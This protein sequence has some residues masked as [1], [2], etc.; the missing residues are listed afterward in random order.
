LFPD[1]D[2]EEKEVLCEWEAVLHKESSEYYY[3]N[4]VTGETTW[5][6]P[7]AYAASELLT[8]SQLQDGLEEDTKPTLEDPQSRSKPAHET[9]VRKDVSTKHIEAKDDISSIERLIVDSV[10]G[11]QL[12]DGG[13]EGNQDAGRDLED[14]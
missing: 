4:K 11:D 5:E 3:W 2:T 8:R 12:K 10:E 14:G 6:K 7:S 9:L 1:V 13:S